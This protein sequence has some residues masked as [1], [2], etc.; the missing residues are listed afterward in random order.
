MGWKIYRTSFLLK[1]YVINVEFLN[2]RT[3]EKTTGVYFLPITEIM[4]DSQQIGT[5]SLLIIKNY[6]L[7]LLWVHECFFFL[8]DSHSKD[9]IR[10]MSA[11]GTAV[12]LKFDSLQLFENYKKPVYYSNYSMTLYFQIP[13]FKTK[14]HIRYKKHN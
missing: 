2:K 3:R 11:T 14:M 4:S 6:I 10:R 13:F 9:E 7:G 1:I 12:L 8:F 5:G